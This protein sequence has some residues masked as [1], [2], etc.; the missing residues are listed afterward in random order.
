[1]QIKKTYKELN[2]E[3]LHAEIRDFALKQGATLSSS[4]LE[5]YTLP[6][7]SATFISRGTLNFKAGGDSGKDC[8]VAHIIGSA[9]TGTK[10][11]LDTDEELFPQQKVS[12]LLDDLE[13]FF[14][15]YEVKAG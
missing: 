13:F 6:N 5:N 11:L 9:K 4:K 2:P 8:L 15:S 3:L 7:D 10:V 14:G 1:M 12:A